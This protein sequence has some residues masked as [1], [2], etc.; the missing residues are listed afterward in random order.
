MN[1]NL[2]QRFLL[3]SLVAIAV[4]LAIGAIFI[5]PPERASILV[6]LLTGMAWPLVLLVAVWLFWPQV[7][8]LVAEIVTRTQRGASI[9]IGLLRVDQ[10]QD[11]IPSPPRAGPVTL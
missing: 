11:R 7:R 8:G 2:R 5:A 10:L 1:K 3:R 6:S 9:Q 4:M